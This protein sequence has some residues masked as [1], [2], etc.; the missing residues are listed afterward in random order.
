VRE[1]GLGVVDQILLGQVPENQI[2]NDSGTM[3]RRYDSHQETI[4]EFAT[5]RPSRQRGL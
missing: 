4:G 1:P 2:P 5:I 3:R